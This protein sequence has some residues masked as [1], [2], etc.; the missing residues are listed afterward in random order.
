MFQKRKSKLLL[1]AIVQG[2]AARVKSLLNSGADPNHPDAQGRT[3][4]IL[5]AEE[6]QVGIAQDLIRAGA[7]VEIRSKTGERALI[8]AAK[9]GSTPVM[10]LLLKAGAKVNAKDK[11][12]NTALMFSTIWATRMASISSFVRALARLLRVRVLPIVSTREIL[13]TSCIDICCIGR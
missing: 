13:C 12:G 9:K 3:P 4:L 11:Y 1:S 6:R 2:Q 7:N 10:E 5:A 8:F